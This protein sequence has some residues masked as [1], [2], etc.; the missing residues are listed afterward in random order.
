MNCRRLAGSVRLLIE[1]ERFQNG[2]GLLQVQGIGG[3]LDEP[4]VFQ[5]TR[6]DWP[7]G[8][9]AQGGQVIGMGA[10]SMGYGIACM[11]QSGPGTGNDRRIVPQRVAA[12]SQLLCN[13]EQQDLYQL[14]HAFG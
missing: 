13:V 6:I 7:Q 11:M 9:G 10:G 2:A 5:K 12:V 8:A 3:H 1:Q 14:C 4:V